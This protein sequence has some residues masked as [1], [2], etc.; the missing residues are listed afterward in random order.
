MQVTLLTTVQWGTQ[1]EEGDYE[2]FEDIREWNEKSQCV[3]VDGF[4]SPEVLAIV[5]N[6]TPCVGKRTVPAWKLYTVGGTL[7]GIILI[8]ILILAV[9][10]ALFLVRKLRK[11]LDRQQVKIELQSGA[12]IVNGPSEV[13]AMAF[14]KNSTQPPPVHP[15]PSGVN[16]ATN[17]SQVA[18]S[19]SVNDQ[20]ELAEVDADPRLDR[21][22]SEL[23]SNGHN[24]R[25]R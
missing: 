25:S 9:L 3:P 14:Q 16:I 23:E 6:S 24:I 7:G 10:G 19:T 4:D 12:D 20:R 1:I 21:V 18:S 5:G 15:G 22:V 8:L 11:K 2:P 17:S 13:E